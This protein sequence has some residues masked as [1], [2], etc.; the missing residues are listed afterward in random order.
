MPAVPTDTP[1]PACG[2]INSVDVIQ[3][4]FAGMLKAIRAWK[5]LRC[6]RCN[7]AWKVLVPTEKATKCG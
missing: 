4:P 5:H 3:V 1:C 7:N 2:A 6:S